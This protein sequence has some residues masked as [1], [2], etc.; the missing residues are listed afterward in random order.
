MASAFLS[1]QP[2]AHDVT[3]RIIPFLDAHLSIKLVEFLLD[4]KLY[5][6][7]ELLGLQLELLAGT[8]MVDM[9]ASVSKRLGKEDPAVAEKRQKVLARL[10]ETK[11]RAAPLLN[12]LENPVHI[13]NL[14]MEKNL[15]LG[16]LN[17]HHGI[18][19]EHV[20]ALLEFAK[21]QF[22]CGGYS[23]SADLLGFFLMLNPLDGSPMVYHA[24]WG[25]LAAL[26]LSKQYEPAIE[27]IS[28]IRDAIES[29]MF[30]SAAAQLHQRAWLMHW[31]LF[32]MFNH[33]NGKSAAI[34][35]FLSEKYVQALQIAAPH[36][37][38]YLAVAVVTS[39]RRRPMLKDLVNIIRQ[40][41]YIYRDP[42]TIFIECLYVRFDFDEAQQRLVECE[43][44]LKSDFF[45]APHLNDFVENARLLIFEMYCR[46]HQKI[47]IK[48][49]GS[50]LSM[51]PEQA[52]VWIVNLIRNAR[53]EARIDSQENGVIMAT[54]ETNVYQQVVEKTRGLSFRS[55][56]ITMHLNKKLSEINEIN[57][58]LNINP[59]P[60]SGKA[61]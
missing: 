20:N 30:E 1:T 37:I 41:G 26:V 33:G 25:R 49:L 27:E 40:E 35:L 15:N 9:A 6:E 18:A 53:L 61:H 22:D 16:F 36:L 29:R 28:R 19:P 12:L 59:A 39:K 24:H 48:M 52:E 14:R 10:E 56:T 7:S 44:L 8:E 57:K 42:V 11:T 21:L 13:R 34:D 3:G 31:A 47:D 2:F 60:T 43:T 58:R 46:I 4:R 23:V 50:K 51:S 32:I 17:A 54:Y 55:A 5:G 38:R 45:L